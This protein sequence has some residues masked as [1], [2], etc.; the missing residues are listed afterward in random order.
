MCGPHRVSPE[1][2]AESMQGFPW[3]PRDR[4]ARE[5]PPWAPHCGGL[6]CSASLSE[7]GWP[8]PPPRQSRLP[9]PPAAV[10]TAASSS[11]T[12]APSFP[13]SLSYVQA[14]LQGLSPLMGREQRRVRG[15]QCPARGPGA[16]AV[17]L[18]QVSEGHGCAHL[19][20]RVLCGLPSRGSGPG[21]RAVL[22]RGSR[23]TSPLKLKTAARGEK[24]SSVR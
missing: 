12:P 11:P 19:R 8:S 17:P 22:A 1:D 6:W 7:R 24:V 9:W 15:H 23:T 3:Y 20:P 21:F 14:H 5:S 18:T 10:G 4:D 16:A 2:A 13:G